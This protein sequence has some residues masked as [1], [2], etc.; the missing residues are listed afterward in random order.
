MVFVFRTLLFSG[1]SLC[2]MAVP[3]W[4]AEEPKSPLLTVKQ[5]YESS[6]FNGE[7]FSGRW[8][9]GGPGFTTFEDSKLP[10]GGRDLVL[11]DPQT[12]EKQILIPATDFAP[13]GESPLR[14]DSYSW[15]QDKSRLL[16]FTNSKRV[17]RTNSRGDYWVLDRTSH[18]L[19]KLGGDS[20]PATLM[21]AK[22]SPDASRVAYVRERNLYVEDLATHKI[23][24]L[25][26]DQSPDI[27]NGTFDWV[28]EEEFGLRDGFRWS[29]DGQQIAFW[30]IDTSQV[31]DVFLVNNTDGLYPRTQAIKYPKTGETNSLC[32]VGVVH[33]LSQK[34]VWMQTPGNGRD[35]YIYDLAWPKGSGE[36]FLQQLNRL[37]N[38][39]RTLFAHPL[40]GVVTVGPEDRDDAWVEAHQDLHWLKGGQRFIHWSESD[41]WEH[42]YLTSRA[43]GKTVKLTPGEFDVT[44][45]VHLDE[46]GEWVYFMASPDNPTQRYLYRT[47]LTGEQLQRLTPAD[48]PGM[49][50]YQVS[51][52]G[53]WAIHTSSRFDK[54]PV[55]E[56]I[57]LPDHKQIRVLVDNK[58]LLER[59]AIL[60]QVSS[61]F[62]RVPIADGVE[63][64]AWCIKPPDFDMTKKYPLIVHVYGEPAGQTVQDQWNG[65]TFLW[66]SLLAQQGYLVMSFDNRGTNAP[67]GRAWRKSIYRQVGILAPQDQAA[68]L[69]KVIETRPYVDATRVGIWGWSGGG[70]MTLNAMLKYPNLYHTGIAIA[71]VPNMR[72]YDTIYQE[73]YMGLPKDNPEGYLK[74]SAINYASQLKGHLLLIHGTGDDNCHYQGQEALVNEFIRHNKPFRMMAYPNR[75]HAISEGTNTSLHLRELMTSFLLE[76]LPAGTR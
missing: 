4:G 43:E 57:S 41:G 62:F 52:D 48:Q 47:K 16:L 58:K 76:K 7:S 63:L 54:P 6:E 36:L 55:T 9:E 53:K 8:L 1:L 75:S 29:P 37:Q 45:L 51:S 66:H 20:A 44:S 72:F 32:R 40:T 27:I 69:K 22:F 17:W 28:Y 50:S 19:S 56:L 21:F 70:S 59:L 26:V 49:H 3:G 60:K 15:S 67:R 18:E 42:L 2:L 65:K 13:P 33:L 10:G 12:G 71:S 11:H 31:R 64:D 35:D 14:I 46:P 38:W 24:P 39:N 34:I 23:V 74:G 30:Q 5:I 25:T 73:R 61:E 68:A